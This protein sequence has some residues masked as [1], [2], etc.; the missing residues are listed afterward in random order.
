MTTGR[1]YNTIPIGHVGLHKLVKLSRTETDMGT[2][3]DKTNFQK[4]WI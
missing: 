4:I 3:K 2:D 1:L